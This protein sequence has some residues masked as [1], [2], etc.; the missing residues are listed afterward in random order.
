MV[1]VNADT[2]IQAPYGAS[3]HNADRYEDQFNDMLDF[4]CGLTDGCETVV[5]V[6]I[7]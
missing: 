4:G 6:T 2:W 1:T 7:P 5:E 3:V